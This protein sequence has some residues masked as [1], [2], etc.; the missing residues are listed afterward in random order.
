[1]QILESP[2]W[3]ELPFPTVSQV[4]MMRLGFLVSLFVYLIVHF[5]FIFPLSK[6]TEGNGEAGSNNEKDK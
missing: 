4:N 5:L 3:M 2:N 1:M 6:A